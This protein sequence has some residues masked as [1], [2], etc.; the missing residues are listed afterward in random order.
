VLRSDKQ[1]DAAMQESRRALELAP[2]E[3][4]THYDYGRDLALHS[5]WNEAIAQFRLSIQCDPQHGPVWSDLSKLLWDH[6]NAPQDQADAVA[7]ARRALSMEQDLAPAHYVMARY[8]ELR[9]DLPAAI[10][11]Y[12]KTLAINAEDYQSHY[13]LGNCLQEIGK[14]GEAAG[15]YQKVLKHDDKNAMA[16]TNLG[17]AY[18]SVG[19]VNEAA[20]YF[21]TA[22]SLKPDLASAREGLKKAGSR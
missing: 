20:Q 14:P 21:Q 3:A 15:E 10:D 12:G 18:L 9:N 11:E 19:K 5:Q 7:A 8:A 4:D 17:Y 2:N 6:A 1:L 13:N 16:W 22:I